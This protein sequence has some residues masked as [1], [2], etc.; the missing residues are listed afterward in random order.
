MTVVAKAMTSKSSAVWRAPGRANPSAS[1]GSNAFTA[2]GEKKIG[3]QPSAISAARATFFG[4]SA[5]KMMGM[6]FR[7]G[8]TIGF[9]AFPSP[10]P[11]L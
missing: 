2:L 8:W 9:K 5:P 10:V 7:R 6:S 11:P 4:P 3:N 1:E